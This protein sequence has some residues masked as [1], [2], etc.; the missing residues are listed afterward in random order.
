MEKEYNQ[1]AEK[2]ICLSDLLQFYK[3][4]DIIN[5]FSELGKQM[6]D[7]VERE[8]YLKMHT[9]K[10]WKG[11]NNSYYTYV[12][13]SDNNRVLKKR[14]SL[15][16][17]ENF[18]VDY[19][20]DH[21]TVND[22]FYEWALY[23]L[24]IRS[25]KEQSYNRYEVDFFR[26]IKPSEFGKMEVCSVTEDDLEKFTISA[27]LDNN[28]TAKSFSGLR[29]I[30]KGMFKY[31]KKKKYTRLS[32]SSFFDDL[33]LSRN[34]FR[35]VAKQDEEEVFTDSEV[36]QIV[37]YVKEHISIW[38]L[39]VLLAFQT[40]MRVGEL[41][42]LQPQD[43]NW[44]EGTISVYKTE[45]RVKNKETGKNT[46]TVVEHTKTEQGTRKVIF[47][48]SVAWTLKEILKINPKGTYLFEN[49]NG[50]RIR[51]TSITSSIYRICDALGIKRR[52][53]HKA[54]K[55]YCTELFHSGADECVISNQVGH[56]DIAT[57]LKYYR[58]DNQTIQEKKKQIEKALIAI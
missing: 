20:K 42:A 44:G 57:T 31:A 56:T 24:E 8:Y 55:T 49:E 48:D 41:T 22:L 45:I 34:M 23:K 5:S 54:R 19:Y 12:L 2:N 10:I 35:K 11:S 1:N 47:P 13:D 18:L 51:G 17:L 25:I 33:E 50:A 6:E 46:V 3:K 16:E 43:I 30:L 39:A 53:I 4:D 27:V 36:N 58:K 7:L 29:T 37:S 21:L 52:S 32:I 26:F 14:N 15:K 28:L 9:H 40:G 38:N